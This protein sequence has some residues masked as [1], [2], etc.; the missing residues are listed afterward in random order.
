MGKVPEE[1]NS[2]VVKSTDGELDCQG[3]S[4]ALPF[5]SGVPLGKLLNSW[6]LGF[7]HLPNGEDDGGSGSIYSIELQLHTVSTIKVLPIAISNLPHSCSTFKE[8][9]H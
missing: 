7:L 4:L 8:F 9:S 3:L 1:K 5:I 2:I 6:S